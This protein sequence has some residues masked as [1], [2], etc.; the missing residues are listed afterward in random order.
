MISSAKK[1]YSIFLNINLAKKY[2][3]TQAIAKERD[4]IKMIQET[5]KKISF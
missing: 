2:N 3:Q 4:H 1:A 5:G